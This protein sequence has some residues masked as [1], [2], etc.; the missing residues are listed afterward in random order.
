ME[1]GSPGKSR[2][3]DALQDPGEGGEALQKIL[4]TLESEAAPRR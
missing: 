1:V 4:D 3:R 2:T